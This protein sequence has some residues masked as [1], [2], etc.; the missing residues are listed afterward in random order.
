MKKES[1]KKLALASSLLVAFLSCTSYNP[2]RAIVKHWKIESI[3]VQGFDKKLASL[4]PEEREFTINMMKQQVENISYRFFANG[5]LELDLH[6]AKL[7][8]NWRMLDKKSLLTA[9]YTSDSAAPTI[10][11]NQIETLNDTCLI[12]WQHN[13]DNELVVKKFKPIL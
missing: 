3:Y 9:I 10:D 12:L 13:L 6:Y 2:K 11:T 5:N 4:P 8:G 7:K 1:K